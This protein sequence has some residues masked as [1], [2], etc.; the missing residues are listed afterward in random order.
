MGSLTIFLHLFAIIQGDFLTGSAQKVLSVG[1]GKIP[2][3]KVKEEVSY[4]VFNSNFPFFFSRDFAIELLG[5]N[6]SK[7]SPGIK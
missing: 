3:K 2:T 6:Q 1:D 4:R 5:L 7:K